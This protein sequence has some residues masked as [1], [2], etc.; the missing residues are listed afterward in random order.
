MS[1]QRYRLEAY[2]SRTEATED[3]RPATADSIPW[4]E[5]RPDKSGP[6]EIPDLMSGSDYGSTLV[7]R[8]NFEAWQ[9]AFPDSEG[10]TWWELYGAHGSYGILVDVERLSEDEQAFLAALDIIQRADEE[11]HSELELESQSEA[12]TGWARADFIKAVEE[13]FDV[14]WSPSEDEAFAVFEEYREL[15]NEYWVNEQGSESYIRIGHVVDKMTEP[16]AGA[17]W[18]WSSLEDD[19]T[20][21]LVTAGLIARSCVF[22]SR[23]ESEAL[24]TVVKALTETFEKKGKRP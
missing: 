14:E 4:S 15:A 6:F 9:E 3:G 16:P 24:A 21:A 19:I 17:V 22:R 1:G 18:Q 20:E 13:A 10:K 7:E 2:Y 11:K 5:V 23:E 12:W 8:S